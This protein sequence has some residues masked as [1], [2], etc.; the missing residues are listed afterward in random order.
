MKVL[1]LTAYFIDVGLVQDCMSRLIAHNRRQGNTPTCP[2]CR[3]DWEQPVAASSSS[4]S[5][6]S[7][8]SS[9]GITSSNGYVNLGSL[10]GA[11]PAP[12]TFDAAG[13]MNFNGRMVKLLS[14]IDRFLLSALVCTTL[15]VIESSVPTEKKN[16]WKLILKIL[17][18]SS[19]SIQHY[20]L[21]L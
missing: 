6:R 11:P 9:G 20:S 19:T 4:S 12:S 10:Y 16:S 1:N 2:L 14:F 13:S 17:T 8:S 3:S 21:S 7:A 5:F 15:L 18:S